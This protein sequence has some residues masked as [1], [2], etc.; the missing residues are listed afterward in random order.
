MAKK[1]KWN[2][3]NAINRDVERQH[4]NKI[5]ADIESSFEELKSSSG[6]SQQFSS[7]EDTVGKMVEGNTEV[8]ISVD[9]NYTDKV[10]DFAVSNFFIRLTGD[11]SGEAEV[12]GLSSVNIPVTLDPSVLGVEEA[13]ID[14]RAY[15]RYNGEWRYIPE[16]VLSFN[17]PL[18][19]GFLQQTIIDGTAL[20][21][22]STREI[23]GTEDE[24]DVVNGDG[25]DANPV[26]SLAKLT[27][28]AGETIHSLRV[29]RAENGELFHPD[30]N[31]DD[32]GEQVVGVSLQSGNVGEDVQVRTYGRVRENSWAWDPGWV[33]CG[34]DGVLTQSPGSSGWLLIIG[35]AVDSTTIEIDI[36][37][38]VFR[39]V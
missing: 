3:K 14:D 16:S 23:Q 19:S 5:L 33:F 35:R 1:L 31:E 32:H 6:S 13:P 18:T 10:L 11:V 26:I 28:P 29:V 20:A 21:I 30:V 9:Y 38:A 22:W 4:L 36:G 24:I 17:P 2:V 25:V 27:L 7:I 8:G 12:V 39:S 37:D 15:A 34:D